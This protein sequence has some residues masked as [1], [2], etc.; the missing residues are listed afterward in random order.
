METGRRLWGAL[1]WA[2]LVPSVVGH[3][4]AHVDDASWRA[5]TSE[6]LLLRMVHP[7]AAR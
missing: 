7:L 3:D 4:L 1:A 6:A 5:T 2:V